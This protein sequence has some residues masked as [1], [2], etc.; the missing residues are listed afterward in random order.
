MGW[1]FAS[2]GLLAIVGLILIPLVKVVLGG[3]LAL[4]TLK[5]LQKEKRDQKKKG[6]PLAE[7]LGEKKDLLARKNF[8]VSLDVLMLGCQG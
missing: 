6:G 1:V 3:G 4:S 2:Q 7:L 5:Y 8:K